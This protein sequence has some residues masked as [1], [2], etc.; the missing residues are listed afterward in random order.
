[1]VIKVI[2]NGVLSPK[3]AAVLALVAGGLTV[4]AI[5]GVL[6]RSSSTVRHHIE[7]GRLHAGVR[8]THELISYGFAHGLL[9]AFPCFLVMS[10]LGMLF[11]ARGSVERPMRRPVSVVALLLSPRL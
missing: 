11:E 9:K 4:D 6:H 8:N 3:E 7:N 10:V 1:M 2:R 5:A